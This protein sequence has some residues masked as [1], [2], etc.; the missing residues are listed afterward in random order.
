MYENFKGKIPKERPFFLL[1][2]NCVQ[3][4]VRKCSTVC[5]LIFSMFLLENAHAKIQ[6]GRVKIYRSY[7]V[8]ACYF[9]DDD[10]KAGKVGGDQSTGG[11]GD[12]SCYITCIAWW[13]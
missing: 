1:F 5:N 2:E 3:L 4:C 6:S 10:D 7:C 13:C 8:C 11:M 12:W 9:A